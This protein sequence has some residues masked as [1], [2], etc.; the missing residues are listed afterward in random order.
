MR[1]EGDTG[2]V[3]VAVSVVRTLSAKSKGVPSAKLLATFEHLSDVATRFQHEDAD[4]Y[5]TAL[6]EI[7]QQE[8]TTNF[9]YLVVLLLG[10]EFEGRVAASV[11]SWHK[12]NTS[13]Q[14]ERYKQADISSKP[15]GVGVSA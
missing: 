2:S 15:L 8:E 6:K 14:G 13:I 9:R 5:R 7:I 3:D 1:K 4:Y 11:D 12:V 10:S